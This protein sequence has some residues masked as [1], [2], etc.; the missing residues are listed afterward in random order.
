[1]CFLCFSDTTYADFAK[2]KKI[3]IQASQVDGASAHSNFPVMIEITG[4][5]FQ[6][7][8][9][10]VDAD[11]YDLV[12]K[13]AGGALLAH[14]IEV[15]NESTNQLVAWVKIPSLSATANTDIYIHYGDPSISSP[16]ETP[17]AVWNSD[18][19]GVWHMNE[20]P[21]AAAPQVTDSTAFGNHGTSYGGMSSADLEPGKMGGAL[22]FDDNDDYIYVGDKASLN[23]TTGITLETWLKP[24]TIEAVSRY[25]LYKNHA[26]FLDAMR[27]A[28]LGTSP[29]YYM[30]IDGEGWQAISPSGTL[31]TN[32]NHMVGTY[33]STSKVM[34]I[35]INGV[36]QSSADLSGLSNHL[37]NGP[38]RRR[39]PLGRLDKNP[40]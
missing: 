27:V 40:I 17:T 28:V 7:I 3:T 15:Y 21:A 39:C 33:D 1:M 13:T 38:H 24:D 37:I 2:R 12:F 31:T 25:A 36:E 6:E 14:E 4:S 30:E 5:H 18:Y 20:N 16:T 32:W 26:Y 22:D 29:H 9:N 35:Y 10:D 11:G 19:R 8:E 34:R 23:V